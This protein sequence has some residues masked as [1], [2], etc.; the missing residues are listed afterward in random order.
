MFSI[1]ATALAVFVSFLIYLFV[2]R[3]LFFNPMLAIKKTREQQ[4]ES[5]RQLALD[6]EAV[7][8]KLN[9]EIAKR[10]SEVRL[11]AQSLLA[12]HRVK[13]KQVSAEKLALARSEVEKLLHQSSQDILETRAQLSEELSLSQDELVQIIVKKI[14]TR[15]LSG[16]AT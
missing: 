12:E 14:S 16:Q 4:V 5:G 6:A 8:Q 15:A 3:S 7:A 10:T 2:M 13:A 9:T 1:D 11:H